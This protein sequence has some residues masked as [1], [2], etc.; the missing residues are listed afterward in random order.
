MVSAADGHWQNTF[1]HSFVL[2]KVFIGVDITSWNAF[3]PPHLQFLL[4][5]EDPRGGFVARAVSFFLT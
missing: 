1:F 3:S 4:H 2:C 5:R